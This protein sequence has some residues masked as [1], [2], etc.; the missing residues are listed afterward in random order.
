MFSVELEDINIEDIVL[1]TEIVRKIPEEIARDNCLIP[2]KQVNGKLIVAVGKELNLTLIEELKFILGSQVLFFKANKKKILQLINTYYCK[3]NLH[4][5]LKDIKLNENISKLTLNSTS[6]RNKFQSSPVVKATNYIIDKAIDER[7]SDLHI[8]PFQNNVTIRMRIDGIIGEYIKIPANIYPLICTRIKI[9]ADMDIAEKR[10]PQDGKIKYVKQNLNYDLRVSTL[11]TIYG[12]KLVLRILYKDESI[13]HLNTLGFL[14]EDEKKV[15]AMISRSHGLILVVGP[16]GSGKTTTLYSILNT[17]NKYEKNIVSIEDPVEYTVDNVNQVN[18]NSKIGLDFA[19]GLRSILRQDP[20][21]IMLG[22]IRDE[23]TAHIAIRAAVTGHLVISTLHTNDAIESIVRLKDMGVAQYFIEDALIGVISQR[24]VRKICPYCKV[25]YISS[26]REAKELNLSSNHVLYKG[27]GCAKC[28]C[29]GYK[30]RT[31][32]YEI[33][34][35]HYIKKEYFKNNS[36]NI[37][38]SIKKSNIVSLRQNCIQLVKSG[39]TTY[40]EFLRVSF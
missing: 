10:I 18:V 33:V 3:Q 4:H 2:L 20:D 26:S 13:K 17:I 31:V 11:P 21:V 34:N 9:M 7:A 22:E 29:M 19:Q 1:D 30:G 8:E 14:K 35:M 23:E 15:R 28:N 24:L 5:A 6:Y 39:V 12:E 37:K 40:E 27:D 36:S 16:T 25:E 32:T 38:D